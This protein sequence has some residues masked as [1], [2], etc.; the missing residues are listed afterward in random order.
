MSLRYVE[1]G[2]L[3]RGL[4]GGVSAVAFSPDGTYIATAGMQDPKV[5]IWRVAD[6]KLLHTYANSNSSFLSLE[7]LPG[8][9]DTLLCGSKGGWISML[10]FNS[11]SD[12]SSPC[13]SIPNM[14]RPYPSLGAFGH[15]ITPLNVLQQW[16]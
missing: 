6:N 9:T 5:Y 2:R 11:V 10:R 1:S 3:Q 7:W 12:F 8:R 4:D 15:M 13:V 14:S 16:M